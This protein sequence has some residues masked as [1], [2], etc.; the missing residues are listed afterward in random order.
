MNRKLIVPVLII[1]LT[2]V[3]GIFAFSPVDTVTA[4]HN[5][6]V[7]DIGSIMCDEFDASDTYDSV[8]ND[9]SD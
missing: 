6:I 4:V 7:D 2:L 5:T 3:A 1:A 9:C 8:N